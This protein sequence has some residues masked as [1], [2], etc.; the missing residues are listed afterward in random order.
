MPAA[1]QCAH[2]TV[3]LDSLTLT[4]SS[5]GSRRLQT[6][7]APLVVRDEHRGSPPLLHPA[8]AL[9]IRPPPSTF[10]PPPSA[11]GRR[12]STIRPPPSA[13]GRRPPHSA[14]ALHHSAAALLRT[15]FR[16]RRPSRSGQ[17]SSTSHAVAG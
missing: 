7:Q 6:R 4:G 12:P 5:V 11:F 10:R 14:A 13:F 1:S 8:A 17:P 9:P 16:E 15:P 3:R 2:S